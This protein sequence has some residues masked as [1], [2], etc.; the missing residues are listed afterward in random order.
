MS[1]SLLHL[2]IKYITMRS[3]IDNIYIFQWTRW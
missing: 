2:S 1:L 3:L